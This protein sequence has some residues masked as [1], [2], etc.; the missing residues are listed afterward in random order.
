MS[1]EI[2]KSFHC[3]TCHA[4]VLEE[5]ASTHYMGHMMEMADPIIKIVRQGMGAQEL[6]RTTMVLTQQAVSSGKTV[7]EVL[8]V[9]REMLQKLLES[10]LF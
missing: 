7:D 6:R 3:P 4:E 9:Y 1:E 2:M 10:G 5:Q 8:A